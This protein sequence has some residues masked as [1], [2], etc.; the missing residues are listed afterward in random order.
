MVSFSEQ[1]YQASYQHTASF[2]VSQQHCTLDARDVFQKI[3]YSNH[4]KEAAVM[5]NMQ[6]LFTSLMVKKSYKEREKTK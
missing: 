2:S 1:G 6:D 4:R 3:A 5:E